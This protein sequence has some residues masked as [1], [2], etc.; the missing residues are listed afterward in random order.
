MSGRAPFSRAGHLRT[1]QENVSLIVTVV[2]SRRIKTDSNPRLIKNK[3]FD[4][5]DSG[6]CIFNSGKAELIGNDIF[7]NA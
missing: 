2:F 4:S 1:K 3:I 5:K 6:I 7:R